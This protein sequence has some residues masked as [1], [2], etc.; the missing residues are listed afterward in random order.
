MLKQNHQERSGDLLPDYSLAEGWYL[1]SIKP[2]Q[3]QR[4][5][6]NLLE[7]NIPVY[8]P[9][10]VRKDTK[11]ALFQGYLFINLKG[12]LCFYFHKIKYTRGVVGFVCFDQ[13][14]GQFP[15]PVPSGKKIIE[16][17]KKIELLINR[18]NEKHT[19][20][21][22]FHNGDRVKVNS[23]LFHHYQGRFLKQSGENRG[24]LLL[25]YIKETRSNDQLCKETLG[26][27]IIQVPLSQLRKI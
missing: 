17:V 10:I 24:L 18:Q 12:N 3:E 23:P 7:Q 9:Y 27:K 25:Q 14:T 22:S 20:R 1:L 16:D 8:C 19:N 11:Q 2:N 13:N 5:E 4:A 26:E 21:H 15:K 6:Q